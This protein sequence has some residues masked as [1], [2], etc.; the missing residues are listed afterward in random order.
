MANIFQWFEHT[1]AARWF[2]FLLTCSWRRC[3]LA[4]IPSFIYSA[5]LQVVLACVVEKIERQLLPASWDAEICYGALQRGCKP[6]SAGLCCCMRL[7]TRCEGGFSGCC[8][9]LGQDES[10]PWARAPSPRA[11]QWW[12]GNEV[13]CPA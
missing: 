8:D 7:K 13:L 1:A 4:S 11:R 9:A 10:R 5:L 3:S 12:G 6:G 2:Y